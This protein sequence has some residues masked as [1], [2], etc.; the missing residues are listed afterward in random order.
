MT[1]STLGTLT[2]NLLEWT[3]LNAPADGELFRVSQS[4]AGEWPGVGSIMLRLLYA[5]NEFYEDGYFENRR[6]YAMTEE[7]LLVIPF[8]PV[9]K[10]AGYTV[11][12]FQAKFSYRTRV[13]ESANWQISLDQFLGES[14]PAPGGGS[15]STLDGGVYLDE[16]VY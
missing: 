8:E 12:Y 1:W 15:G 5:D 14:E 2:P 3:T 6:I 11:R 9:M 13:Y 10:Q 4:W 16:G 7:R